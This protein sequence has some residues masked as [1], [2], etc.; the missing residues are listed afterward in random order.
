MCL[1]AAVS[2]LAHGEVFNASLRFE[3]D[4][5]Q[6]LDTRAELQGKILPRAGILPAGTRIR[7]YATRIDDASTPWTAHVELG[8]DGAATFAV[9]VGALPGGHH[10]LSGAFENEMDSKP[11]PVFCVRQLNDNAP[12]TETPSIDGYRAFLIDALKKISTHQTTR[13]GDTR[14]GAAFLSVTRP[15]YHSYRSIGFK[16]GDGTFEH[17]W[18][19]EAPMDYEPFVADLDLWPLLVRASTATG[20]PQYS[21]SANAMAIAFAKAGFDGANGLAYFGEEAGLDVRRNRAVSTKHG[22][23][24]PQFKPKNSGNDP[25]LPMDLLWQHEPEQMRRM[26]RSMY[27][28][29]ITDPAS[30]D[31]NRYCHYHWNDADDKHVLEQNPAHCAFESVGARMIHW[32]AECF[33]RTGDLDCLD[34]AQR[35]TDKWRAV[36]HPE[37]GLVPDFFGAVA[38]QP[39]APMPPGEWAECRGVSL[40]ALG[41]LDAAAA[42]R[43]RP[44]GEALAEQLTS[45]AEK[46]ALGVARHAYD[47]ARKLFIEHLQLD[48]KPYESTARYTF[49]TQAEKDEAIKRDP[50]MAQVAVYTGTGL[51]RD[52]SYWEHCA[53]TSIVYELAETARITN[54]EELIGRVTRILDDA[55]AESRAQSAA[56]TDEGRWTFRA[57]GQYIKASVALFRATSDAK[58]IER[59]RDLADSEIARLNQVVYPEWW[60]MPERS[61]FVDGLLLLC[62]NN[63]EAR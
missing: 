41:Y 58:H 54:N 32:W 42:L 8:A 35:M 52:P 14:D 47:G 10:T 20:D 53:G 57:S 29:L 27:F 15:V 61:T 12:K 34:Y 3:L 59:A 46:M 26:C 4:T 24:D 37:S 39:G 51:Y 23:E 55:L 16:K 50:A 19:P 2:A 17:Y 31:Y 48:G 9:P 1:C 36:Q 33:A 18:F 49:R 30:M 56:F 25:R 38:T 40:A 62:E 13:L 45:M 6:V 60:R 44:G 21:A 43:K 5:Y 11:G 28:G 22:V 7:V 63:F